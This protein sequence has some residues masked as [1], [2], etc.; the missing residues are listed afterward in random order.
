MGKYVKSIYAQ[1]QE[2]SENHWISWRA[3]NPKVFDMVAPE[4]MQVIIKVH[5][6]MDV[7]KWIIVADN[8][9]TRGASTNHT[10]T[11]LL[12]DLRNHPLMS[13]YQWYHYCCLCKKEE[14]GKFKFTLKYFRWRYDEAIL[15]FFNCSNLKSHVG[16]RWNVDRLVTHVLFFVREHIFICSGVLRPYALRVDDYMVELFS[17][18]K[19]VIYLFVSLLFPT[20]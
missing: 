5:G 20:N 7:M 18:E 19:P 13:Y 2:Y 4:R 16:L 14:Q 15:W 3:V 6:C 1:H 9:I 12:I 11:S 17:S 8:T 10:N